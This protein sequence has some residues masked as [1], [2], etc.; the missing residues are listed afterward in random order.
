MYRLLCHVDH[1]AVL[2]FL[3]QR[4]VPSG[5]AQTTLSCHLAGITQS[6]TPFALEEAL[7]ISRHLMS[8]SQKTRK[9]ESTISMER[10]HYYAAI[11]HRLSFTE[12]LESRPVPTDT[13]HRRATAQNFFNGRASKNVTIWKRDVSRP[14]TKF[15]CML[16]DMLIHPLCRYRISKAP[17]LSNGNISR[18]FQG[19]AN[20]IKTANMALFA[21]R[22]L[23][24]CRNRGCGCNPS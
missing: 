8:Y 3:M 12:P 2:H 21:F 10:K 24:R 23:L 7:C 17:P 19:G 5:M 22:N 1:V 18:R 14:T 20:H 16:G 4:A 6:L 15:P 13:A 9:Q 11:Y